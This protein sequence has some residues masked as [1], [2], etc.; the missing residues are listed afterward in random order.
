MTAVLK[1]SCSAVAIVEGE[2]RREG[3]REGEEDREMDIRRERLG[4]MKGIKERERERLVV[5]RGLSGFSGWA[6]ME[7]SICLQIVRG[8]EKVTGAPG[9]WRRCDQPPDSLFE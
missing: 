2:R 4:E 5:H 1:V 3:E 8:G 9:S 7:E 6:Q